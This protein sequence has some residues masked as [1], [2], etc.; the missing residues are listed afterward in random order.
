VAEFLLEIGCEELPAP[1]LGKLASDLRESFEG[2]ARRERLL[3]D[4]GA[5]PGTL[6]P[7]SVANTRVLWTPRRLVL[8]AELLSTQFSAT[9]Q[10]WGPSE[11]AARDASGN[12]TKAA[13]GFAR[14]HGLEP[15]RLTFGVKAGTERHI[16]VEQALPEKP[17]AAV[18]PGLIS[19]ALRSLA[20]PKRM[21]WDAWL[22]DGKGAFPFGRPIRW[23][24]AMLDGDVLSFTIH[25]AEN[26][27]KGAAIVVSG[28]M[29]RGHRFL[30][31]GAPG[32]P[33]PVGSF[34]DL[35]AGLRAAFVLVD[36][37]E[38]A[39]RIHD[40]LTR[41]GAPQRLEDHGLVDEWRDLVEFPT[42]VVGTIPAEFQSLPAEVLS[43][44][45]VH[46]QKYIPLSADG[47]SAPVRF[48]AVTNTD[49]SAAAEIVRGMERVVIARLRDAA[50]FFAED[51]KRPLSERVPDLEGVTFHR[52]LGS[53][54]EKAE[55]MARLV[56]AMGAEMGLLTKPEHQAAREAALLAK[57]D[58]TTLMV[59]EF[60]ELQGVMGGIYLQAEGTPWASVAA[61]VRWHYFPV[62][63]DEDGDPAGKVVGSDALVFGAVSL[64]DKLDTLAGYFGIGLAPTGSSDPFGLRRAGQGVVRV[65]IDLWQTGP[66]ERRPSLRLLVA[67]AVA[68]YEARL[69]R[70]PKEVAGHIEEFLLERL[71]YL[72]LSRNFPGDEVDA[73]LGA[74]EPDAIDDP[75]EALV[76]LEALHKVRSE[77]REDFEHLAV[78]FKRA[79]NIRDEPL[80]S[81]V[82]AELFEEDAERELYDVVRSLAALDGGYEARLRSLAGLRGPVDRFFDDVLVMADDPRIRSNRLGLLSE[83]L[84]LFYRIADISK[85][86]G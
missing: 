56:D 72:L 67:A 23:L 1:W 16:L 69:K 48:A 55:R 15:D 78:A 22:D 59:R 40:G 4:R 50:F 6:D 35:K 19:E 31:K 30:P 68:G 62:S 77:A 5:G 51:R 57:A 47:R 63:V 41:A 83:A 43:T 28:V 84:S 29:T 9:A 25:S 32:R 42:V 36:P 64:A 60:P 86:G 65:L 49:G 3:R 76:R 39:A 10:F 82:I 81:R 24:V 12:W 52:D 71:R 46:H 14:K 37:E 7:A 54:R 70:P 21:N 11:R 8:A 53:Y 27:R 74:R 13:E 17:A 79:K 85:L 33:I 20:F 75:R 73:V 80:R 2:L 18:L 66:S 38:R 34:D 45:L 44:V 58:L 61:A 26:G